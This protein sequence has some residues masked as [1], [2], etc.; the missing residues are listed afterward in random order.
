MRRARRA[1][2]RVAGVVVV[3]A[4]GHCAAQAPSAIR[5]KVGGQPINQ[6]V[7]ALP[8]I[9]VQAFNAAGVERDAGRTDGAGNFV[10]KVPAADPVYRLIVWDE[11]NRWWGREISDL[12]NDAK[13]RDLGVIVLRPQTDALSR[14]QKQEESSV[15]GWLTKHNPLTAALMELHLGHFDKKGETGELRIQGGGAKGS[16]ALQR[17]WESRYRQYGGTHAEI[18]YQV[19]RGADTV[20]SVSAGKLDFG[21]TDS[22][23]PDVQM[24]AESKNRL[25]KIPVALGGACVVYHSSKLPKGLRFTGG[26]LAKMYLGKVRSWNDAEMAAIN[27]DVSLPNLPITVI[28]SRAARAASGVFSRYLSATNPEWKEHGTSPETPPL[29]L[30]VRPGGENGDMEEEIARRAGETD[31]AIAYVDSRYGL[32]SLAGRFELSQ[33][34]ILNRSGSY[35]VPTASSITASVLEAKGSADLRDSMAKPSSPEGYPLASAFWMVVPV[36]PE[37]SKKTF[38]LLDY[39]NFS[40]K[41]KQD[42]EVESGYVPL[43]PALVAAVSREINAITAGLLERVRRPHIM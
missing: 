25:N 15:L 6:G 11:F 38:V 42:S 40:L 14:E 2:L 7:A 16:D 3:L 17:L 34:R 39:I 12:H 26:L 21:V 32:G 5:G 31:G 41:K 18:S 19:L 27:P 29:R 33:G 20:P 23:P 4:V 24:A 28:Y 10:L 22:A 8:D 36:L 37:E 9:G 30:E 13:H 43:P 35:A 1:I